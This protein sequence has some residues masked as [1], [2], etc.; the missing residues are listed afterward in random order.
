MDCVRETE[1]NRA[2]CNEDCSTNQL[3]SLP[4]SI[5][6]LKNLTYL[7]CS[8]NQLTSLPES[9][10]FTIDQLTNLTFL[11]CPS[12]R[13]ALLPESIIHLTLISPI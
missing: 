12:N 10:C 5:N 4:E 8:F 9:I 1:C 13:L 3:T 7:L 11:G 2:L 6:Q